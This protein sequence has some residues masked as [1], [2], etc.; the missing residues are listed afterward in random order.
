MFNNGLVDGII[1]EP[2]G[3]AHN[4][5]SEAY[6]NIKAAILKEFASLI[7]LPV[8]ELVQSRIDKFS[9]MGVVVESV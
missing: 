2:I 1:K 5:P 7:S 3:G 6:E 9:K 8:D 4:N